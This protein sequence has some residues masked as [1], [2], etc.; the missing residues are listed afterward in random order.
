MKRI[1]AIHYLLF[2]LIA[3]C[4]TQ[5]FN[6]GLAAGY[7]TATGAIKTTR[8]LL[9]AKKITSDDGQNVLDQTAVAERGLTLA[10]EMNKT[11]SKAA[12]TKL[13]ATRAILDQL[14]NYLITKETK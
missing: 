11:D 2:A 13:A 5:N 9:D 7:S 10:R 14:K 3:G 12:G 4:A 1:L 8:T 6:D